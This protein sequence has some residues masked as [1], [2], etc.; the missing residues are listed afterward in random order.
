MSIA[1]NDYKVFFNSIL[2]VNVK[3]AQAT[4]QKTISW[5]N[6]SEKMNQEM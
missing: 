6:K 1:T 2:L 5:M 3:D 4:L